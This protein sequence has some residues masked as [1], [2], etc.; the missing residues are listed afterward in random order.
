[1]LPNTAYAKLNSGIPKA[2]YIWRGIEYAFANLSYDV[3]GVTAIALALIVGF[4]P[5]LEKHGRTT[6]LAIF[7]RRS[8]KAGRCVCVCICVGATLYLL[9][10]TYV[11][12]DFMAG[13][14]YTP[15][16]F[17]A[18]ILLGRFDLPQVKL[19]KVIA[20]L[21]C[22]AGVTQY[23]SYF[24]TALISDDK[25]NAFLTDHIADEMRF[26]ASSTNLWLGMGKTWYKNHG[27]YK[28]ALMYKY[29]NVA[30]G[31]T[32][33][34]TKLGAKD[35]VHIIDRLA[36]TDPLLAR[37]PTV[38]DL[39]WRIGHLPRQIP[40]GYAETLATG[41]NVIEDPKLREYYDKLR[42]ITSGPI[43]S[44]KRFETI[45]KMN[46]GEYDDLIDKEKYRYG[47]PGETL[48]DHLGETG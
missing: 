20:L 9:Y 41:V 21:V 43:F 12:G 31:D 24:Y 17:V 23:A 10:V 6:S 16:I 13:R 8:P 7:L 2:E 15:V 5:R 28:N 45:L 1:L 34:M 25:Y 36:L 4:R 29:D 32:V 19:I 3:V 42:L 33:G 27:F 48:R 18:A 14:L 35:D 40:K 11:G 46:L 38:I 22:V 47:F 26:Y 30:T 44:K 39:N 37:I